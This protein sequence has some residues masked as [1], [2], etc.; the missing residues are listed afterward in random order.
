MFMLKMRCVF[1]RLSVFLHTA[2]RAVVHERLSL[3]ADEILRL[4]E[5]VM[6]DSEAGECGSH[7]EIE[8]HRQLLD[9]TL[10]TEAN[11]NRTGTFYI[12]RLNVD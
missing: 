5:V 7:G 12:H 10:K 8:R 1:I 4:L 2:Q 3:L 11:S 6:G 9:V